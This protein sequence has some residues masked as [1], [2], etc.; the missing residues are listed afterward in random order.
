M[1]FHRRSAQNWN[2]VKR[3]ART[4]S[5]TPERSPCRRRRA[6]A[7]ADALAPYCVSAKCANP[8]G[9]FSG[10]EGGSDLYYTGFALRGLAVLDG[11]TP[12]ICEARRRFPA[13]TLT[14]QTSVVDFFSLLYAALLVQTGGG[15]DVFAES[16]PDWPDRVAATLESF[17]VADG[18]YTKSA[19][20][21]SGSTYHTFLVGLAYQL[22]GR[23]LPQPEAIVRFVTSR[24]RE[25]G[26]YVE[27]APMPAAAQSHGGRHRP[28]ATGRTRGGRPDAADSP[29]GIEVSGGDGLTGGRPAAPT[30]GRRWPISSR[31][32]PRP[33]P[34][35]NSAN[36]AA[37][38]RNRR[39]ATPRYWSAPTAASAAACGMTGSMWSTRFTGWACWRWHSDRRGL[40]RRCNPRL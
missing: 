35:T 18:G 33:G 21:L 6:L 40:E 10:R 20:G 19:G 12:A 25:D 32:L 24:R 31:R 14:Q 3:D 15:P 34:S 2:E 23:S 37:S 13:S 17:R 36:S 22:L 28:A 1:R 11:L 39:C 4:V 30:A 9:G 7:G 16:P 26:G 38:T 8:D 5:A 27:M 29:G